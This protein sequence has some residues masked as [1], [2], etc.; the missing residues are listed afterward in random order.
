LD[1]STV[2]RIIERE[3]LD[4]SDLAAV[5]HLIYGRALSN[6]SDNEFCDLA[7]KLGV[8]GIQ[9][10]QIAFSFLAN[11]AL[12]DN[13]KFAVY[14]DSLYSLVSRNNFFLNQIPF[15]HSGNYAFRKILI[16]LIQEADE[17]SVVT[18]M[19]GEQ[20][21]DACK[22]DFSIVFQE[23]DVELM[24]AILRGGF[25]HFWDGASA[26]ILGSD[27]DFYH[28][29][30]GFNGTYVTGLDSN[31]DFGFLKKVDR[32]YLLEWCKRYFPI[33]PIR[34][35]LILPLTEQ[36]DTG[37][38]EISEIALCMINEFGE[39]ADFMRNISINMGNFSW[40]GSMSMFY[41]LLK[42]IVL[43]MEGH[44][45]IT[46]QNWVGDQSQRLD[47]QIQQSKFEEEQYGR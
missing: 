29:K 35:A 11:K 30:S 31:V 22:T 39:L 36:T 40:S 13:K 41:A 2:I 16:M 46:V 28:F 10:A 24:E 18:K 26:A 9:C 27:L 17:P 32:N 7:N 21:S 15:P 12:Y 42:E 23:I 45:F 38:L 25:E 33:A 19:I 20:F 4:N 14:K 44:Q 5:Y 6:L 43:T 47:R 37:K 3:V 8:K 34:L 1:Y